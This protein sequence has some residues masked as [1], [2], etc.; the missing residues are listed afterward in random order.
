MWK[1]L[2]PEHIFNGEGYDGSAIN[3]SGRVTHTLITPKTKSIYAGTASGGVWKYIP[4]KNK[5]KPLTDSLP[6]SAIGT[7][8]MYPHN[9]AVIYAG[10]GEAN[11]AYRELFI[12]KKSSMYG[13]RGKGI[14]KTKDGGNTWQLLGRDIFKEAA[15]AKI[16]I[17]PLNPEHILTAT[18]KGLF[19]SLDAGSTWQ[20]IPFFEAKKTIPVTDVH[21]T[22]N[23]S[24]AALVSLWG[25]GIFRITGLQDKKPLW[26]RLNNGLPVSNTTRIRV[27]VHPSKKDHLLA[28]FADLNFKLRG[29]FESEDQGDS[30][31]P[32]HQTPDLL[33][34]HG[35]HNMLL[36][37]H[38]ASTD[39]IYIGGTGDRSK[40]LSS[41]YK[42]VR[43][44]NSWNFRPIGSELH[45]DLH[46]I[47]FMPG[48]PSSFLIAGDGGIWLTNNAGNTWKS[49]NKGLVITQIM[50]VTRSRTDKNYILAGAMDNGTLRYTE[51]KTWEHVDHGDGGKVMIHPQ[52]QHKVF[53]LFFSY[54]LACSTTKGS[55][56][57]FVRIN[58]PIRP[59]KEFAL[60]CPYD[61][62]PQNADHIILLADRPY[63]SYDSGKQWQ[64]L[65]FTSERPQEVFTTVTYVNSN[66]IYAGT[67][68]GRV[69]RFLKEKHRWKIEKVFDAFQFSDT[70]AYITAIR[71]GAEIFSFYITAESSHSNN[72]WF[73]KSVKNQP[74]ITP[75][76]NITRYPWFQ[77]DVY[78]IELYTHKEKGEIL[79]IAGE[80]GVA[81]YSC[82]NHTLKPLGKGLP[83][84]PVFDIELNTEYKHITIAS[85]GRGVWELNY[86]F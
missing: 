69:Y 45:I 60:L 42:G 79:F 33:Q 65:N 76:T 84:V 72:V 8:A 55:R 46:A 19:Q 70:P 12:P 23:T 24:Q 4:L 51:S 43:I 37:Y 26:Q 5:W 35:F 85:F 22:G 75:L 52:N 27:A 32:V 36:A 6:V 83:H 61:L 48:D 9:E 34:G 82:A 78:D 10:T 18:T 64:A 11:V 63:L 1:S 57:S 50:N 30:W 58:P 17:N 62:N 2:G 7:L 41:L 29:L 54:Y 49:L 73:G 71:P 81:E 38:P 39:T 25:R 40:H 67:S 56:N 15:F 20:L 77:G 66:L 59:V 86:D 44:D 3:V 16:A 80:F 21:F 28:L 47:T 74:L 68:F 13:D 14:L 53:N 31:K